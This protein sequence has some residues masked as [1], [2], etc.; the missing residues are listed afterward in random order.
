MRHSLNQ[1]VSYTCLPGKNSILPTHLHNPIRIISLK[2][3]T[4]LSSNALHPRPQPEVIK[5][6]MLSLPYTANQY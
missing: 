2:T 6:T 3:P 5:L 4:V 1:N